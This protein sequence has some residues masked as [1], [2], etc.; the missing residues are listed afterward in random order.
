MNKPLLIIVTGSPASGKTTLSHILSDKIKYPLISRDEIKESFI[1]TL[2]T[3]HADMDKSVDWHVYHTFFE[4]IE[5]FLTKKISIIAEAAFQ[6]KLWRPRLSGLADKANIKIIVCKADTA[7]LKTRFAQRLSAN[8]DR[9]KYHGDRTLML[10]E[11]KFAAMTDNYEPVHINE[12]TLLVDTTRGYCP[13]I[14]A[15]ISFINKEG[16][17]FPGITDH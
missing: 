12:A 8:A 11:E 6:D 4:T 14:D 15:I 3:T 16:E 9:E 13:G 7:L 17:V 2:H 10:S 5:G 1:N